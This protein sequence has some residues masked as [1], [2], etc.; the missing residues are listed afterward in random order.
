[1]AW[2]CKW[3]S[4]SGQQHGG[5]NESLRLADGCVKK[6]SGSHGGQHHVDLFTGDQEAQQ[7]KLVISDGGTPVVLRFRQAGRMTVLEGVVTQQPCAGDPGP[8][9]I[10]TTYPTFCSAAIL[11]RPA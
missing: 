9:A 8:V 6:R 7:L 5:S 1:M 2:P 3:T 11:T 4:R 10:Q